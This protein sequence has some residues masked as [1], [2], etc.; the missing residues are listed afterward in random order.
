MILGYY[1][2]SEKNVC[3]IPDFDVCSFRSYRQDTWVPQSVIYE[4][5]VLSFSSTGI[6]YF[7]FGGI[8][9]L[10]ILYVIFAPCII[11]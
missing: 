6:F 4:A 3:D 11:I 7:R 10:V 9:Y 2:I 8:W 5:A 1:E